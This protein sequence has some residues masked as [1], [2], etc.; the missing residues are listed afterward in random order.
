MK[1]L[2]T[3]YLVIRLGPFD[4]LV[5]M[6]C[7]QRMPVHERVRNVR[8]QLVIPLRFEIPIELV[9]EGDPIERF[10]DSFPAVCRRFA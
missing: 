1:T 8:I 4:R 3:P 7:K 6:A 5:R 2:A 9:V 10:V